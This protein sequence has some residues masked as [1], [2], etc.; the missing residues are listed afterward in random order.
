M[1][2]HRI[3]TYDGDGNILSVEEIEVPD[4]PVEPAEDAPGDPALSELLDELSGAQTT[5]AKVNA[6]VAYFQKLAG[7]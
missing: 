6:L 7:Q 2:M 4:P 1:A 5:A 3:E